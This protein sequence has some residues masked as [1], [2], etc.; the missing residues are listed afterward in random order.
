MLT[1]FLLQIYAIWLKSSN[2]SVVRA[3]ICAKRPRPRPHSDFTTNTANLLAAA[4][5]KALVL[6]VL[7]QVLSVYRG[8]KVLK[9]LG[10]LG[11]LKELYVIA[12]VA[13]YQLR[14]SNVS[15]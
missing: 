10:G 1:L 5:I 8:L 12:L 11:G 4:L 13:D 7:V 6:E 14:I 9:G 2:L 3:P 15:R